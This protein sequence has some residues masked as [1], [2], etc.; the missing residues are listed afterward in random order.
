MLTAN[1]V[2]RESPND[3]IRVSN[4]GCEHTHT[5]RTAIINMVGLTKKNFQWR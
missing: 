3:A 2:K 5:H 1:N 4:D